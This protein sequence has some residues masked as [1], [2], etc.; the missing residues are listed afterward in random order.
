MRPAP[1]EVVAGWGY[2]AAAVLNLI[3][4]RVG[5][6]RIPVWRYQTVPRQADPV[7][8]RQSNLVQRFFRK[9]EQFRKFATRY[10]ETVTN[11]LATVLLV[12]SRL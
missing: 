5:R 11:W 8:Y 2:D 1:D 6:G 7:L 12:N 3:A 4:V 9:L 10:E